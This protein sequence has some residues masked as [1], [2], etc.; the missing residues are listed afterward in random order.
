MADLTTRKLELEGV[1]RGHFVH[2]FLFTNL[3]NAQDL[4]QKVQNMELE[5]SFINP[6]LVNS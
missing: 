6:K 4:L 5:M 2:L 3:E 1:D